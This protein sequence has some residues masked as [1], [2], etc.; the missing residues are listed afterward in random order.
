MD[1]RALQSFLADAFPQVAEDFIVEDLSEDG[2][3]VRLHVGDRHLRPGGTVSGPSIFALADVGVYLM[4]LSRLGPVALAV[5]T[6]CS[7]DF[8]RKPA[9]G[10]DLTAEVRLLKLGRVLAVGD[11]LIYSDGAEAPVARASVT[12]SIPPR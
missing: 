10:V 11:V 8:M 1:I 6:N 4:I 12:Y 7:I 9:A 3:R 5:T 2:M